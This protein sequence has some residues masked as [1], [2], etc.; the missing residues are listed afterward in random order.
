MWDPQ[1]LTNLQASTACYGDSFTFHFF[2]FSILHVDFECIAF[3]E[4][5]FALIVAPLIDKR[6]QNY[7][8]DRTW[9]PI[10]L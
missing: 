6:R 10:G 7:P 9:R 5:L 1:Y 4:V 3:L 2:G 8:C